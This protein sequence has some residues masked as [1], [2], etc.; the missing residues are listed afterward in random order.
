[1]ATA[2]EKARH[3]LHIQHFGRDDVQKNGKGECAVQYHMVYKE[4]KWFRGEY[5]QVKAVN[6]N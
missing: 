2:K 3:M 6:H 4:G 1:M 5:K